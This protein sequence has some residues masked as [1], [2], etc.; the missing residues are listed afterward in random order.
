MSCTVYD[1]SDLGGG[2]PTRGGSGSTGASSGEGPLGGSTGSTTSQG[3]LG[4]GQSS[5]GT[6]TGGIGTDPEGG[7]ADGGEDQGG[8]GLAEGGA[9]AT[10]GSVGDGGQV[11][12]GGVPGT[13][14]GAGGAPEEGGAGGE[15][16]TGGVG[17]ATGGAPT[18]GQAPMGGSGGVTGG[19]APVG[20]TSTGGMDPGVLFSDDFEDG[21]GAW[22]TGSGWSVVVDGSNVYQQASASS[23]IRASAA[24]DV[25]WTDVRFE[26][27]VKVLEFTTGSSSNVAALFARYGSTTRYYAVVLIEDGRIAIRKRCCGS[28]QTTLG[29][30]VN[31]SITTDTWYDLGIEVEGTTIRALL[32]GSV[33]IESND[34]DID[35]GR[36]A[37]G[38]V[39]TSAVFD[40]VVV[41]LP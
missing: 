10:G 17:G 20:G 13:D 41:T 31:R 2:R 26:A 19:S 38:T 16:A 3:G 14:G 37:L 15:P 7:T 21:A 25:G 29:T 33:V 22:T 27:R 12:A 4:G 6:S 5:G 24:G 18:G 32:N 30:P 39:N 28:S 23:S 36:I 40:D 8:A 1:P 11:T 9:P 35:A 34:S